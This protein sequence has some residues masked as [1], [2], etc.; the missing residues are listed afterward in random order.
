MVA[1]VKWVE[2]KFDFDIPSGKF[3][4]ILERLSGTP[5]RME[6]KVRDISQDI[7]T[8]SHGGWSVQEHAG[9]LVDLEDLWIRRLD[10]FEAGAAILSA[11][12][13]GNQKTYEAGHNRV[14]IDEILSEFRSTRMAIVNRIA[15]YDEAMVLR[16]SRHPR[17]N[18]P[19]RV[20]DLAYFVAEHDDHHLAS[21]TRLLEESF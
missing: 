20:I 1:Q 14:A 13:M 5:A 12:D 4:A 18:Q 11:A 21:M 17:L 3:P 9:H 16:T 19:M 2:L 10:E 15:Q 6:E 7:L 8:R